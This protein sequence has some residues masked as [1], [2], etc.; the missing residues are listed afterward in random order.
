MREIANYQWSPNVPDTTKQSANNLS[1]G[2]YSLTI[3]DTDGCTAVA[4]ASIL[5][6]ESIFINNIELIPNIC[7]NDLTGKI[8]ISVNGGQPSYTFQW[9]NGSTAQNLTGVVA[10]NYQISIIDANN[11]ELVQSFDLIDPDALIGEILIETASCFGDRDGSI[12]ILPDG[13]FPPYSYSLDGENYNGLAKIVGLTGGE[14]A[15][16]IKDKN[17]CVW[18]S[19]N[20]SLKESPVFKITAFSD[21]TKVELGDSTFIIAN[22]ENNIG[23]IQYSWDASNRDAFTCRRT[24]CRSILAKPIVTTV[25]EVYALDE[26]GCEATDKIT[27][28]VDKF[29][30]VFVP[31]GFSPNFDN[32]NDVLIIH[33]KETTKIKSF[34]VFDRWGEIVFSST[35][36]KINDISTSWDGTFKGEIL[37]ASVFAWILEVEYSDGEIDILKGSTTLIR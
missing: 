1:V 13:G 6:P 23:D 21:K 9:S 8:N 12:T 32:T 26:N 37:N 29:R 11:C 22:N 15:V 7:N 31:T 28:Q 5:E 30:K 16:F 19:N 20:I 14:Y 34:K 27:I 25:Y 10:G 33:G 24:L 3:S 2:D 4:R 18:E 35:D 36:M 17:D